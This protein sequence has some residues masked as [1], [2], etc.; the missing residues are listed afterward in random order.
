[1]GISLIISRN[2]IVIFGLKSVQKP[3]KNRRLRRANRE[4]L[5]IV[6]LM[7]C[8][9]YN[10]PKVLDLRR[11]LEKIGLSPILAFTPLGLDRSANNG[12]GARG[13]LL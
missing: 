13:E 4:T 7:F 12:D 5:N 6:F 10:S 1:M 8:T 11:R 2:K 3:L 9:Q